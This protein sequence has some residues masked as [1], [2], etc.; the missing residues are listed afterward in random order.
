MSKIAIVYWS[1]TGNTE[2]MAN[3]IAEGVQEAG[4]EAALFQP[5]GF[6]EGQMDGFGAIAFG[7]PATGD[8]ALEDSE[9]E[10]MFRALEPALEGKKI[11]LFGSY[12]WGGGRWMEDWCARCKGAGANLLDGN[13]LIANGAPDGDALAACRD[14]GKRLAAW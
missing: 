3:S 4:G 10:P 8:E 9:F 14:L 5:S 12:G 6:S 7:C 13:G 1:G 2:A 11:A